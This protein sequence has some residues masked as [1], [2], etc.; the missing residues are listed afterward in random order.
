VAANVAIHLLE[1]NS[2]DALAAW[3]FFN[4]VFETKEGFSDYVMEKIAAEMLPKD[5]AL[6]KDFEEK[7]KDEKFAASA[8]ARLQFFYDRSPYAEKRI[9]FYPVGRIVKKME[10]T[11][12]ELTD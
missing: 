1:P 11:K 12:I 9:G 3:G 4:A 10:L 6:K 5:A 2:E 7:L 8:S